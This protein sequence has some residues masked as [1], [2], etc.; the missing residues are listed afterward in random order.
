MANICSFSMI[1]KGER[2]SIDAFYDAMSQKGNIYMGR[3]A[4]AA[5]Q[6]E[7]EDNRAFIDGWCK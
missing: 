1:V 3:G 5:I 4:D 2:S 6:Y 7:D